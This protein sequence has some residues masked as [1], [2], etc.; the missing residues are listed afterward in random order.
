MENKTFLIDNNGKRI[1]PRDLNNKFILV[2]DHDGIIHPNELIEE[3]IKKID[4]RASDEYRHALLTM[5]EERELTVEKFDLLMMEHY[6]IKDQVLEEVKEEFKGKIPYD[7][8]YTIN[9]AYEGV[10]ETIR[11]VYMSRVFD[12]MILNSHRNCQLEIDGK[13]SFHKNYLPFLQTFYPAFHQEKY[14]S[15]LPNL[16]DNND[17]VRTNK[18]IYLMNQLGI[19][20]LKGFYT[21]DDS[22]FI[23]KEYKECGAKTFYKSPTVSSKDVIMQAA[24]AAFNDRRNLVS[25]DD[26]GRGAYRKVR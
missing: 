12:A 17:R 11:F 4:Y 26:K 5:M 24:S 3:Y 18:G 9:N 19:T 14:D 22:S 23:C 2:L 8:I 15:T 20:N 16:W 1:E 25:D 13:D 21:V 6:F 10:L 7:L